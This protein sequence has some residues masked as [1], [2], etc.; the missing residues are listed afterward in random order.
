[1]PV[2][3]EHKKEQK[4][5]ILPIMGI[6]SVISLRRHER[7]IRQVEK[8][9]SSLDISETSK[10]EADQEEFVSQEKTINEKGAGKE[11]AYKEE[12][13]DPKEDL[14]SS[15]FIPCVQSEE[16]ENK[17]KLLKQNYE[18]RC[19]N[20]DLRSKVKKL[21]Q[22]AEKNNALLLQNIFLRSKVDKLTKEITCLKSRKNSWL[23]SPRSSLD[24]NKSI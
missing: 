23:G 8:K 5:H 16:L 11:D 14:L 3:N 20:S 6:K 17:E 2:S 9:T 4:A 19:Q 21:T 1:M 10:E 13:H 24:M 15:E 22:E 7:N 12:S 18:L